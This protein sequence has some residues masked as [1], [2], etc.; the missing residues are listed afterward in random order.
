LDARGNV[1]GS[2]RKTHLFG[3]EKERFVAGDSLTPV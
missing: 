1:A 2:Y 3:G